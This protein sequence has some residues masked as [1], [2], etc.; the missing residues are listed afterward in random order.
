MTV[1]QLSILPLRPALPDEAGARSYALIRLTESA[2]APARA[3]ATPLHV[4]LVLDRS[5]SMSG[6]PL[7]EARRCGE[8]VVA[9]LTAADRAALVVY[10]ERAQVLAAADPV[11]DGAHLRRAI[12]GID[13]GGMTDL[14]AGWLKGVETLAPLTG[15]HVLS[16]VI[17]LSD[18]C[19]NRGLTET[20][21]IARQC[22]E[23][24]DSGVTTSTYGLGNNFNEVLMQA[25][26]RSGRGNA[27]YGATAEDLMDPF[28]EEL[29]LLNALVA[30]RLTLHLEPAAGVQLEVLNALP[31]SA[32]GG[33]RLPD[34]AQGAEA[35]ALV[36]VRNAPRA[37]GAAAQALFTAQVRGIDPDGLPVRVDTVALELPVVAAASYARLP[38]AQLVRRRLREVDAAASVERARAAAGR[39][40]WHEVDRLLQAL[41]L[42]VIDHPWLAAM[43]QEL[44]ALAA[45]R[46]AFAFSKETAYGALRLGTRLAAPEEPFD[47]DRCGAPLYVQRKAAQGK[48]R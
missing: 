15:G 40:D 22:A 24:A 30:Q 19:A 31:G 27:Y 23:L 26:A 33:W 8:F 36:C 39:G 38:E 3:R 25:M 34:L 16:R 47:A 17:L 10:D 37:E 43:L 11:G 42:E 48:T 5:G 20:D 7:A 41:R 4:A 18:G 12:A 13:T 2:A 45:R 14:H 35:W 9:G 1:L 44:E 46:D 29:A 6:R 28:R 21:A 32:A